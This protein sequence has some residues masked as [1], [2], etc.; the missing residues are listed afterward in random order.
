[1]VNTIQS[2]L[3]ILSIA[4]VVVVLWLTISLAKTH[5]FSIRRR[6]ERPRADAS[7][8]PSVSLIV[9]A[10]NEEASL[11][12]LLAALAALDY[13]AE[14][15]EFCVVDERSTDSTRE[16][17]EQFC[18]QQPNASCLSM[19]EA[20]PHF[21]PKKRAIDAAIRATS[22]EII[23]LTDADARP[24]PRWVREVV[25]HFAPG[26]VMVCGYS[27]YYPRNTAFENMLALEYFSLAAVSAATIGINR[28]MTCTGSNFAY[29]RSAYVAAG[30]FEGIAHYVSG[31]DDLFL[32]KMHRT[33][34]GRIAYAGHGGVQAPVR[35]PASW[36]EFQAQ[37][38]RYASKGAHY[39][40][41]AALPLVAVYLL[42]LLLG[43]GLLSI[44]LGATKLFAFTVLCGTLKASS[45]Y[46]FLKRA[47]RWFCERP[48]LRWFIPAALLHPFYI[49]Y[50]ST[51]APF[52]KFTWRGQEYAARTA[53]PPADNTAPVILRTNAK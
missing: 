47:A 49:V 14:R 9:V 1:M 2:L 42:N 23:L 36:Y 7:K 31:D 10:R 41:Q 30:G 38:T 6:Q 40:W 28:P 8:L 24:G 22:G 27:P 26:V 17:L 44:F 39:E 48:L 34:L 4:Y 3:T 21:A 52:V 45:E 11:P 19:T 25:K 15:L 20:L 18:A 32:H 5:R 33:R 16:L 50:F 53:M 46:F 35:A 12:H 13:P 29:R 43:V 37:R 51:R